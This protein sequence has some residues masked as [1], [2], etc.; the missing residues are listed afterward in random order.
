MKQYIINIP[1]VKY[2]YS[3]GVETSKYS[4]DEVLDR[5]NELGLFEDVDDINYAQ[6]EEMDEVFD[7]PFW[8]DKI[9]NID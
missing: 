1:H 5:V 9:K 2:G 3:L 6:I 7:K 4:E 8:E